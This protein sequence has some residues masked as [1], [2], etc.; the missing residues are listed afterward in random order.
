MRATHATKRAHSSRARG[1]TLVELLVVIGI[2]ALLISI[3]LPALNRA[4]E[5]AMR[6]NCASALRQIGQAFVMYANDNNNQLPANTA[7]QHLARINALVEETTT[8]HEDGALYPRYLSMPEIFYCPDRPLAEDPTRWSPRKAGNDTWS[9]YM[10]LGGHEKAHY[11]AP[12]VKLTDRAP[13]DGV[14]RRLMADTTYR[15][16]PARNIVANHMSGGEFRG[17]NYLFTDIHVEWIDK[18][19]ITKNPGAIGTREYML[20][21]D[22]PVK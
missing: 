12:P 13:L 3:L 20:Y 21:S 14:P 7:W 17:A 18:G 22:L 16:L 10:Y 4:R 19:L 15:Q 8:D 2:I 1:F 6:V 5:S 9:S 11:Y